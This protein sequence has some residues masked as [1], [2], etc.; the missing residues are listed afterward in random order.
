MWYKQYPCVRCRP[1]SSK[2][3]SSAAFATSW[4]PW[5]LNIWG[6]IHQFDNL[7]LHVSITDLRMRRIYE[8]HTPFSI[9]LLGICY[10]SGN[11]RILRVVIFCESTKCVN[12]CKTMHALNH[13]KC[14]TDVLVECIAIAISLHSD[15]P[16]V[17]REWMTQFATVVVL[18]MIH[19]ITTRF[20]ASV[21]YYSCSNE[22]IGHVYRSTKVV[23]LLRT[24]NTIREEVENIGAGMGD[25]GEDMPLNHSFVDKP[26]WSVP[27]LND[28]LMTLNT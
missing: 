24:L 26:A 16:N 6:V 25:G 14:W 1:N 27:I 28:L 15:W 20:V 8:M 4:I 22:L 12:G 13:S 2:L 9:V 21:R 7:D 3:Y 17:T 19:H 10:M 23:I 5:I 18:C 11:T